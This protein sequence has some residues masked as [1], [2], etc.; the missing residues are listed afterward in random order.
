MLLNAFRRLFSNSQNR[1]ARRASGF[2]KLEI[3]TLEERITPAVQPNI[4]YQVPENNLVLISADLLE[5]VPQQELVNASV[6][7]LDLRQDVVSQI[8]KALAN[9]KGIETLRIISHGGDGQLFFGTQVLDQGSITGRGEEIATWAKAMA[10]GAD[11]LLYGCSVAQ[12]DVGQDFVNTLS[13]LTGAD[14]AASNNPTGAGGDT[15]LEYDAGVVA[16]SLQ[17]SSQAWN[18]SGLQLLQ[19]GDFTYTS[20]G[21]AITITG[22]TGTGGAVV[23]PDTIIGLPIIA[24]GNN[25]FANKITMTSV[26]LPSSV[27]TI[28]TFAFIGCS[29]LTSINI[30]TSVTRIM[31]GSFAYCSGLTSIIIPDSVTSLVN[32]AFIDCTGLTSVTIGS[33]VNTIGNNVFQSCTGLTSI[34]IPDTV[35]SIEDNAFAYCYGLKSITIGSGVTTIGNYAIYDCGQ[36]RFINFLGAPPTLGAQAIGNPN[37]GAKVYYLASASGWSSTY[38]GRN[39]VAVST[40]TATGVSPAYATISGGTTITITGTGFAGNVG[41]TVGGVAATNINVVNSTSITAT[42]PAGTFGAADIVVTNLAGASTGSS[43]FTYASA[44]AAPTNVVGIGMNNSASIS[45]TP[46][47]NNGAPI[48]SYTVT[49][50]PGNFTATGSGSSIL[51]AGLTNGTSYTFTVKATNSLGTSS[52]SSASVAVTAG[53]SAPTNISLSSSSIVENSAIGTTIGIFSSSDPDTGNTF[54]YTLVGGTGSTDNGSFTI[55]G[56]SLK[57]AVVPDFETQA[58]YSVRIRTTD[59]GGLFFEKP[60]T[61]NIIDVND[62]PTLTTISPLTGASEGIAYTITYA[63]LASAANA[64]DAEGSAISFRIEAVTSGTLTKNGVAIIAG[65]TLFSAG[66]SLVYTAANNGS[67]INAFT[68]KAFDGVLASATAVQVT[69]NVAAV[70]GF[71]TTTSGGNIT[72]IGY[73][74]TGGAVVIPATIGGLPVVAIGDSAFQGKATVTSII[75]PSSIT[76]IG[77]YAFYQCYGLASIIIPSS[78]TSIGTFAAGSGSEITVDPSNVNYSSIDGVLYNKTQTTLIQWPK[79]KIGS[80]TIPSSVTT[81]GTFAF[82]GCSGLTSINIPTS[83]TTLETYAFTHCIG[84]TSINIPNSVTTI[85]AYAFQNCNTVT[86]LTIPSSVTSIGI[87]AFAGCSGLTSLNILGNITSIRDGTFA[88]CMG[89]TSITI[90]ST[91]TSIGFQG[92]YDCYSLTSINFLGSPATLGGTVFG[93]GVNT[94]AKVYYLAGTSGWPSIYE[95]RTTVAVSSSPTVT[96]VSP[97]YATIAGGTTITITGTGFAGIMGVTVGGVAA[98]NLIIVSSTSITVKT[99]AGTLGAA[100]IIVTNIVGA[101]TGSSLFNYATSAPA[102]PT[103]V[104]AIG[105]NNSASISFTPPANNGAPITS[106]TVTSS[107]GN[108]TA[109]SSGSSI[110][111]TGLTNGTSY[112]F[113]VKATNALGASTASS[114][115]AAVTTINHAPTADVQT[116]SPTEDMTYTGTLLGSD[117]DIGDSLTYSVVSQG[118]KGVVTITNINTGTFTYVPNGNANGAD[119]FTFKVNDGTVNS[120]VAT[121]TVNILAANDTPTITSSNTGTVAENAAISTGIYTATA[122]DI[123]ASA[124]V[125][126]SIK[127]GVGDGSLV[128]ID[129]LTG[130]VTLLGSANFEVKSSYTFT[131]VATDNGGLTDEK[132]VTVNVTDVNEAPLV[133]STPPP[134]SSSGSSTVI[135]HDPITGEPTGTVVPF[136][137]FKGPIKVISGD[138]NNDGVSEMI[139]GAG[140]GGGPAIVILNSQTGEVMESFF[141][142]DPAFIGG[143]SVAVQD[144]NNDGIL[145]IIASAGPGGGP[146]VRI[147]DGGSLNVLRAFFA[148]DQSFAGGVSIATLDFNNDGI[149]DLVTG[150]GP[151]GAPHVKVYDGA[152]NAII[153][154]W[155]AYPISFTGGVF[156]TIGDIGDDGTFEVVTGAGPGGAPVVAVWDP[157]TGALLSQF[158]AYAESFTGGVRVGIN[159][160]NNDGIADILTGAGPG[161]GPHVKAFS[162]P[163]LDL[164][165]SFY[166]GEESNTGGVF[167]S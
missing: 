151:D 5:K 60:F 105:M 167:V 130:V 106:Y 166:S 140:F 57:L 135:L 120:T 72:I 23:I 96:S 11:L 146:E 160:G 152:T 20:S 137:G 53:N 22:Y 131:V 7:T 14:V 134:P 115:S 139:A 154:Q 15:T 48:T 73:T 81:I 1:K 136:P 67:T 74:G 98:T 162:F 70:T 21:T 159:D 10:P 110:L 78:V 2:H 116:I 3:L 38:A 141:A 147:F 125:T 75:I 87:Y 18:E 84:L 40:P 61:I 90:P 47:A 100:D 26:I 150:A 42:T 44:P 155:Y 86:S 118:T 33:G 138:I 95:G 94:A 121:I 165:F 37:A 69:L 79:G 52:A 17:A 45:F 46:P 101:G 126:Y 76:S 108:F 133:T 109:T 54:T 51:V 80:G 85:G 92:F 65:S 8:S 13:R 50:S 128:S 164:L 49:S 104:V 93:G 89:L 29:G 12:S 59:A 119:S 122:T 31:D 4:A 39:T 102:A 30:P 82:Y 88:G 35:T 43:L 71:S 153:S 62:A 163:A 114:A 34:I 83:V 132:S 111:V 129:T 103:N 148:Y 56:N 143:V 123:D 142:F 66:D 9:R 68:I 24:F 63:A 99:P 91:V 157:Y 117:I 113:T 58:F 127:S 145:D 124:T 156:V 161:G 36:L 16:A 64:A 27:T 149:L 25:A 41:V 158:M 112:T 55:D 19:S 97:A 32:A 144:V 77:A 107:P 6:I 28:G